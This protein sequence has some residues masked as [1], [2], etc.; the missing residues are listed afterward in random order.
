[1]KKTTESSKGGKAE[2]AASNNSMANTVSV[3]VPQAATGTLIIG[4]KAFA[5]I[6]AI[7]GV[8]LSKVMDAD[9]QRLAQAP[10]AER[11]RELAVKYGKN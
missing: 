3:R 5:S 9:F 8:Y 11:R 2:A 10:P 6:S 4:R 7:E 1:M